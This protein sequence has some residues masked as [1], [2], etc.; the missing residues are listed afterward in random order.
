MPPLRFEFSF[1]PADD[2][3]LMGTPFVIINGRV[4]H[5]KLFQAEPDLDAWVTMNV[6]LVRG[7]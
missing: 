3:G 7:K 1:V 4:F 6:E 5:F 2:L